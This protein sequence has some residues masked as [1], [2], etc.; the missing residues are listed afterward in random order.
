[1]T[2]RFRLVLDARW[3]NA[4]RPEE[5]HLLQDVFVQSEICHNPFQLAILFPQLP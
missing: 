3:S 5:E 4:G 2:P 1:M